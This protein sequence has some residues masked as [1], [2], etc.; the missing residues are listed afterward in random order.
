MGCSISFQALSFKRRQTQQ[1]GSSVAPELS[2]PHTEHLIVFFNLSVEIE[3]LACSR[4]S[5]AITGP[6]FGS[7][8]RRM[9]F[10]SQF[11]YRRNRFVTQPELEQWRTTTLPSLGW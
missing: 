6:G 4:I 8:F 5:A 7:G 1:S 11:Q 2:P 10:P 3:R 9:K